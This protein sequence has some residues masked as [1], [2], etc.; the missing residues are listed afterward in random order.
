MTGVLAAFWRHHGDGSALNLET[1]VADRVV[2]EEPDE[3]HLVS[4]RVDDGL[5]ATVAPLM[6]G[7]RVAI[8]AQSAGQRTGDAE[9]TQ[10]EQFESVVPAVTRL[11]YGQSPDCH[12]DDLVDAL[13]ICAMYVVV[14]KRFS[15]TFLGT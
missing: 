1:G 2:G 10:L 11:L 3:R 5:L 12:F 13:T 15:C 6:T 9:R 14:E 8:A 4:A 7:Q